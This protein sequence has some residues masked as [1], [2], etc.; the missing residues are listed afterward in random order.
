MSARAWLL[1]AG[2]PR[3]DAEVERNAPGAIT[4]LR[5]LQRGEHPRPHVVALGAYAPDE[6]GALHRTADARITVAADGAATPVPELLGSH[7]PV[8]LVNDRDLTYCL[9]SPGPEGLA[10]LLGSV[11]RLADP[12]A[13]ALGHSQLWAAVR[14][15]RLD[16]RDYVR[17]V[18]RRC[19]GESHSLILTVV[20]DRAVEALFA[21]VPPRRRGRLCRELIDAVYRALLEA[22]PGS[23]AQLVLARTFARIAARDGAYAR[24]IE[25]VLD[26]HGAIRGLTLTPH[27]TWSLWTALVATAHTT[28]SR[29][30]HAHRADN[31]RDGRLG[32]TKAL[33]AQ[34]SDESKAAAWQA[35]VGGTLSNDE[36]S[37]TVSGFQLAAPAVARRYE[38]VYFASVHDWWAHHSMEIA[39]RLVRGLYPQALDAAAAASPEA[40]PVAAAT[41]RWLAEHPDAAPALRRIMTELLD[42]TLRTLRL[43]AGCAGRV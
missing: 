43:Q 12:L 3:L 11:E 35:A 30:D 21:Y 39:T 22:A 9:A 37:A 31:S 10:T 36:L 42:E 25:A 29:L 18:A 8:V 1:T 26:G 33:A 20:L 14:D 41:T 32:Y 19:T 23:D 40:N 13:R 16:P 7:A 28:R 34:L 5:V 38:S 4:A 15:G 24:E 2:V 6:D 27:L 17:L